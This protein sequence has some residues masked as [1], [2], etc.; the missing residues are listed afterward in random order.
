M[1]EFSAEETHGFV[2]LESYSVKATSTG[3]GWSNAYM[4]VQH[5]VPYSSEFESNPHLFLEIINS[6]EVN[7]SIITGTKVYVGKGVPGSVTLIPNGVSFGFDLHSEISSTHL[8]LRREV[9]NEVAERIYNKDI[10]QVDL[11]LQATIFD[12]IVEQLCRAIREALYDGP[13][14]TVLYVDHLIYGLAAY[15]VRKYSNLSSSSRARRSTDKLSPRLLARTRD[16]VEA[17]LSERLT[18]ADLAANTGMG[19]DHYGRL[20]KM[21]T[22][23]TLYQF[24]IRC[25][26]ERARHLLE[27]TRLPITEIAQE[28]GFA[29]Q[30]HLTRV[31]RR[32]VGQTPAAYRRETVR[33]AGF[34]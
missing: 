3:L 18:L 12:P 32:I 15:L 33:K 20:F 7:S 25:R 29:D 13:A 14:A 34:F 24:V 11:G 27:D 9:I 10:S 8:Y 1:A 21:Q 16:L 19:P 23:M 31:F 22:G 17:R 4:S 2:K 6:G 28:C 30:V 5:A 26:V